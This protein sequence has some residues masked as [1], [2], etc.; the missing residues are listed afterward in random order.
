[1]TMKG[2]NMVIK[3][4]QEKNIKKISEVNEQYAAII[5]LGCRIMEGIRPSDMLKDRLDTALKTYQHHKTKIIVSG[6]HGKVNYDEVG[7]MKKY[8]IENN[9]PSE[10]IIM[11]HNG[12][13]TYETMYRAK[14]TFLINKAIII[15]QRYHLYRALYIAN[16]LGIKS[17][18]IDATLRHYNKQKKRKIREILAS[19]KDFFK[20]IIKPKPKYLDKVIHIDENTNNIDCTLTQIEDK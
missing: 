1:M 18:G 10:D 14:H 6:D 11:D 19:T 13:S 9:V 12:F 15:T 20:C 16:K 3:L 2:E 5:V 8:L 4:S 17:I 7:V